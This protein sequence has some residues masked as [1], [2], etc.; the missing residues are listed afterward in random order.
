MPPKASP[1]NDNKSLPFNMIGFRDITIRSGGV[2]LNVI[3]RTAFGQPR[4]QHG[5]DVLGTAQ[6]AEAND[7]TILP[8]YLDRE[9]DK[10]RDHQSLSRTQINVFKIAGAYFSPDGGDIQKHA[11]DHL[12]IVATDQT[13]GQ[14]TKAALGGSAVVVV[15]AD[16]F[17]HMTASLIRH[18]SARAKLSAAI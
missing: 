13:G 5:C 16:L 18:R 17:Y 14:H 3:E 15:D 6:E 8:Y 9:V 7:G 4:L 12:T 1:L 10:R 2:C 11:F